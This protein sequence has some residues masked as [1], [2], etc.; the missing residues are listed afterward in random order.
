MPLTEDHRKLR[1]A[2]QAALEFSHEWAAC[3]PSH[4]SPTPKYLDEVVALDENDEEEFKVCTAPDWSEEFYP[5]RSA[6]MAFIA[7]AN[8]A[9]I[10]A[11]LAQVE[12]LSARL[13]TDH[14]PDTSQEWA[15]VDPAVAFHLIERHADDWSEAGAMMVAWADARSLAQVKAAPAVEQEPKP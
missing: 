2:A 8:P 11:L 6:N 10:L 14:K 13:S 1:E 3:G 4:G 15:K 7:A 9:A 5:E 12:E